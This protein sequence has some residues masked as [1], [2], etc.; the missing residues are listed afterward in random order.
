MGEA[1]IRAAI[2]TCRDSAARLLAMPGIGPATAATLL[3]ELPDL[4]QVTCGHI[5]APPGL[6]TFAR[7]GARWRGKSRIAA[8][9]E[10]VRDALNLAATA[11]VFRSEAQFATSYKCLRKCPSPTTSA[12]TAIR[13]S[14]PN[15]SS[16]A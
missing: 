6:A 9:R 11:C 4:G 3:A 8:G 12:K 7:Q 5:A 2:Q 14:A 15:P 16:L 1:A 13:R 10:P